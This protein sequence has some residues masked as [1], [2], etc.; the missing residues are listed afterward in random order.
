[1]AKNP[2]FTLEIFFCSDENSVFEP[3][4]LLFHQPHI[5]FFIPPIWPVK[6]PLLCLTSTAIAIAS[7]LRTGQ[8]EAAIAGKSTK[9]HLLSFIFAVALLD[10]LVVP[11]FHG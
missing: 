3:P 9:L 1:M 4:P 5:C 6:L 10:L 7:L 2:K 11:L 8:R